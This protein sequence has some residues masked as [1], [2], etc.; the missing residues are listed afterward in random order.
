M[1][2]QPT[3]EINTQ[4]NPF[5]GEER[6][7]ERSGFVERFERENTANWEKLYST[8]EKENENPEQYEKIKE[9]QRKFFQI[10]NKYFAC[11]VKS[12][13]MI[14]DQKRA[15]E[16]VL[17]ERFMECLSNDRSISQVDLF[18]VKAELNPSDYYILKEIEN[19]LGLLGFSFEF[20]GN[21]E[22]IING[23]PAESNS[24]DPLEMLEILLEDYKN[25]QADPSVGAKEKVAAGMA[26]A[27]A[28]Q[29]G[30]ILSQGEMEDLFDNL[31]ACQ[32]PNYSPKGKPVINIISLDELDKRF[33]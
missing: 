27:S 2:E 6:S 11:P 21:N 10:K 9:T 25:T 23:R 18:P 15:H 19:E 17:Y 4:F 7:H 26:N 12:G 29:Y 33:K 13:L 28:I 8:L 14:I 3:I 24:S 5:D 16:R 22:I 32:S 1:P 20:S 30:K 31:F